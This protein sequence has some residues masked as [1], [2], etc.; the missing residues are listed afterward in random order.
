M[1]DNIAEIK[2]I[3]DFLSMEAIRIPEYQRPYKWTSKNVLQ[4]V[5]D[6]HTFRHKS[7]YRIGTIVI[8][9]NNINENGVERI[10]Y[11]IVDGQQRYLTLRILIYALQKQISDNPRYQNHTKELVNATYNCLKKVPITF[12]HKVSIENI[13]SN[14]KT[15]QRAIQHFDDQTIVQFIKNFQVVVFF[16]YDETEAFQFFDSQNSRGKDLYPHDL[17]KAFHLREFDSSEKSIQHEIIDQWEKYSTAKLHELF[18]EY[19]F[20]IKGWSNSRS[21]RYF[22][23]EH[24]EGF[25]G[26]SISKIEE[27]PY[28]KSLQIAHHLVDGY[29]ANIERKIDKQKMNFPFQIDQLMING[30]RFFEYIHYYLGINERFKKDYLKPISTFDSDCTRAEYLVKIVYRNDFSYRDGES[31]LKDLFECITIYYIDKFGSAEIEAFIEKA[32]VWCYFLRFEFQRLGFDSIDK[33]VL[34]NNLFLIVK[35]AIHP[36]DVIKAAFLNVPTLQKVIDFEKSDSR[37][38]DK[39]I[40]KFFKENNYYAN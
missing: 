21:S 39:R 26:I 11:D 38:M 15:I 31:Y 17:L 25:K 24:I 16:I 10:S 6:I 8:H 23:K 2:S 19:L 18:S 34:N 22:R 7:H 12:R 30:R 35:K 20:R 5:D 1:K 9:I 3:E 40:V 36:K 14:Y 13:N 29:N 33:Y 28:V 4:L 27:Y 32:F 37:R